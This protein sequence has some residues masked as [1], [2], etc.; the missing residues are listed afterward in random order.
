MK[1][2]EFI[3]QVANYINN[4]NINEFLVNFYEKHEITIYDEYYINKINEL[5]YN[6]INFWISLDKKNKKKF[7]ELIN[8]S[9]NNKGKCYS[10]KQN[11]KIRTEFIEGKPHL[12][13]VG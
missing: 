9:E 4:L 7:I 13:L 5:K 6:F 8:N 12:V 2:R 11:C 3:D 1:N 10:V